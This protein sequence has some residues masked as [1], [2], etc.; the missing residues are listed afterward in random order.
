MVRGCRTSLQAAGVPFVLDH[1]SG[2]TPVADLQRLAD[3]PTTDE[4]SCPS[5]RRPLTDTGSSSRT[6][7]PRRREWWGSEQRHIDSRGTNR[8]RASAF[9][10]GHGLRLKVL[11]LH[12]PAIES[13]PVVGDHMELP[14]DLGRE[15]RRLSRR[16]DRE[17]LAPCLSF[18]RRSGGSAG[19]VGQCRACRPARPGTGLPIRSSRALGAPACRRRRAW[20]QPRGSHPGHHHREGR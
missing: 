2:H 15:G 17:P 8:T 20:S 13:E 4:D 9:L 19:H 14:A 7:S 16:T 10:L 6:S 5:T 3:R 11:D 18:R 1:A 12:I